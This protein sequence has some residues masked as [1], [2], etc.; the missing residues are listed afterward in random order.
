MKVP[1][2]QKRRRAMRDGTDLIVNVLA[3]ELLRTLGDER[4]IHRVWLAYTDRMAVPTEFEDAAAATFEAGYLAALS[5][6]I[7][8][9]TV[10]REAVRRVVAA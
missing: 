10:A 8:G 9:V 1:F 6:F 7:D 2:R 5:E 4:R 3:A